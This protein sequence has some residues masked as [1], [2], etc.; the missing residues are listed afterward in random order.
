MKCLGSDLGLR[1]LRSLCWPWLERVL[2]VRHNSRIHL[3]A[4]RVPGRRRRW[5]CGTRSGTNWSTTP[6]PG[7][8]PPSTAANTTASWWCTTA[9]TTWRRRT[10]GDDAVGENCWPGA[11]PSSPALNAAQAA[12][13]RDISG[14]HGSEEFAHVR[15]GRGRAREVRDSERFQNQPQRALVLIESR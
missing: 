13:G 10:R 12:Q 15:S 4:L 1:G 14:E 5:M 7:C 11:D 9:R 2:T 6:T 8:G 3:L